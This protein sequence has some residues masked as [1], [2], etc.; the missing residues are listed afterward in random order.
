[1]KSGRLEMIAPFRYPQEVTASHI[2]IQ[3]ILRIAE[4]A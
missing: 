1:M 4:I 3:G 2:P